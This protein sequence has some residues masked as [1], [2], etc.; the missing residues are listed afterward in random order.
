MKLIAR[1]YDRTLGHGTHGTIC[2]PHSIVG[3]F[4]E[5][6]R[7]VQANN[8]FV[9]RENDY[10]AHSC[11]HCGFGMAIQGS[12]TVRTNRRRTVRNSDAVTEFCGSGR[13]IVTDG[14]VRVG[15]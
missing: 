10:T 5:G 12:N 9:Q 8:R 6:S 11:P 13:V 2:C 3:W 1:R 14:N 4:L 15:D 7:N